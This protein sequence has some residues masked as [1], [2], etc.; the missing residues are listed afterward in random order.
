MD[1]TGAGSEADVLRRSDALEAFRAEVGEA[2][3]VAVVGG[4]TQ[5]S[6]GGEPAPGVRVVG[7]PVGVVDHQPADMTVRV[8]AGTPLVDLAGALAAAGQ[9]VTIDP[10][11]R[12]GPVLPSAPAGDLGGPTVGG[13]LAV[14][15]SGLRRLRYG[16][17]RDCL[18]EAT[19]VS[20]EGRLVRAGGP[21]VKNVSGFDLGR[22]MVGSLGTL[23]L[24]GEVVLRTQ[25]LPPVSR[26]LRCPGADPARVI[27]GLYRPAS[28][29]W[30][31]TGVWVLLEGRA[32]D[33]DDQAG[34]LSAEGGTEVAG[35]PEAPS[36]GRRSLPPAEAVAFCRGRPSGTFVVEVGVGT[37]HLAEPAPHRR[38]HPSTAGLQRRIKEAFDPEGRLNPGRQPE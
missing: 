27:A 32:G 15:R 30:D 9:F 36:A 24:L 37:V 6:V 19:W 10:P 4:R 23:G 28:V 1:L 34:W 35:P 16:P 29:L 26:W 13:L 11:G 21:V 18:L 12:A 25:P 17:T 7:A 22:L 3:P 38:P 31:G 14:G 2:G 33:V 20:A 5:W 8:G